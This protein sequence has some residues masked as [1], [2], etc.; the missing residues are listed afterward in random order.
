MKITL[1][2]PN[3]NEELLRHSIEDDSLTVENFFDDVNEVLET[4]FITQ[5]KAR[6]KTF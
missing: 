3:R 1:I 5:P 6:W 2:L 4:L